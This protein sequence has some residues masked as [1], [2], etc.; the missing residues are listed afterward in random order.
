VPAASSRI[1]AL[2]MVGL[3]WSRTPAVTTA[4]L[5]AELCTVTLDRLERE[6]LEVVK[7]VPST[8]PLIQPVVP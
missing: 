3:T 4:R 7:A 8:L 5:A 2:L 1:A 6:E